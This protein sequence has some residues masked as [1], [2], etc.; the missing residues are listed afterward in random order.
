MVVT[1]TSNGRLMKTQFLGEDKKLHDWTSSNTTIGSS[2]KKDK[3]FS[4]SIT[5]EKAENELYS[6][7]GILEEKKELPT[8]MERYSIE[9]DWTKKLKNSK[10]R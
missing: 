1:M 6:F 10:K 5:E 7:D 3:T 9:E 4:D 2:N 8:V